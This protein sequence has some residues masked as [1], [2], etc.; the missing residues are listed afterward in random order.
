MNK[1]CEIREI[2]KRVL[3]EKSERVNGN[4]VKEV[5]EVEEVE[6]IGEIGEVKDR[7]LRS[8]GSRIP[9]ERVSV[10]RHKP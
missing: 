10:E 6:E 3:G 5:K 1:S 7:R 4:E 9:V 2:E 8:G